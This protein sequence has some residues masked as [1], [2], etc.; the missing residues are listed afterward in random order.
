[1]E[2]EEDSLEGLGLLDIETVFRKTK[3]TC[4][5]KARVM[6]DQGLL[7]GLQ[8][9]E[10]T[11]YEI[12]MGRTVSSSINPL[13][14]VIESPQGETGYEDGAVSKNGLVWGT[15]LH[16]I[17]QSAGFTERLLQNLWKRRGIKASVSAPKSRDEQYNELAK[18][19]RQ[20]LDME[21][22]YGIM[23]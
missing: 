6:S 1:V 5:V 18:V 20:S 4:Q 11:G 21:K 10:V 16:G 3:T 9:A 14:R 23:G 7:E 13:C 19:V 15:Y 2:S 8:G 22:V 17:F 12:H